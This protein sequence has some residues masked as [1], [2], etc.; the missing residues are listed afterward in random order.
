MADRKQPLWLLFLLS[1]ISLV[2]AQGK[3]D[4]AYTDFKNFPQRLFF[5]N[6]ATVSWLF[7]YCLSPH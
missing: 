4:V 6:D 3:P 1:L 7:S 2:I 5:F